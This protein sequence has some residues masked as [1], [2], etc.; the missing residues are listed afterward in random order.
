M[1]ENFEEPLFREI[2]SGN[3]KSGNIIKASDAEVLGI[4]KITIEEENEDGIK[5]VLKKDENDSV[6][7]IKFIC[8]CGHTK[9]ILL[10]YTEQ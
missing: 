5:V 1:N 9:S 4:T 6:K 3:L 8:S 7:E 2:S 10:D